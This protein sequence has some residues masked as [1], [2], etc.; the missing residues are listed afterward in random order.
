MVLTWG[1]VNLFPPLP[2]DPHRPGMWQR[3]ETFL[4]VTAAERDVAPGVQRV[5]ARATAN[6]VQN[7]GPS[8]SHSLPRKNSQARKV[9]S[10]SIEKP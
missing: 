7:T 9:K 10:A 2:A 1:D 4:V 8:L 5:E 6:I 3:L